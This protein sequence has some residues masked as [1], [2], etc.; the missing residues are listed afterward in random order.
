MDQVRRAAKT[1][2]VPKDYWYFPAETNPQP[3][4]TIRE[5]MR[6]RWANERGSVDVR[7]DL[8]KLTDTRNQQAASFTSSI[9]DDV[10]VKGAKE[11]YKAQADYFRSNAPGYYDSTFKGWYEDTV[12]PALNG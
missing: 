6:S 4:N 10:F 5:D 9:P 2:L 12:L 1:P 8:Q 7:A 3:A 11:M